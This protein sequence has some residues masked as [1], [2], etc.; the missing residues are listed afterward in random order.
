[1][2]NKINK[3][4][5]FLGLSFLLG[6]CTA[7][8]QTAIGKKT[9]EGTDVI[10]DFKANETRGI[11]LPW[12]TKE[13]EVRTP[14]GGTLIFDAQDKKVKYY[15]GGTQAGWMDLSIHQGQVDLSIQQAIAERTNATSTVIGSRTST[16]S[17]V[18]VLEAPDK[19]MVLPKMASP[20]INMLS[21]QAGTIAFDTVS[22]MLCV[23][24]GTEWSFWNVKG[25]SN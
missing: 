19:A 6:V 7:S 3:R 24:N 25:E 13:Q 1:M 10:L 5:L 15:R 16:A 11:I 17:G 4:M 23:F 18:L 12:V 2:M 8:G 9:T 14:V 22:K 20:H 21:P